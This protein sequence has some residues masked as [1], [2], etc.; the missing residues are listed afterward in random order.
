MSRFKTTSAARRR[1]LANRKRLRFAA[2]LAEVLRGFVPD[3]KNEVAVETQLANFKAEH[4][5]R[6]ASRHVKAKRLAAALAKPR[7]AK[8][9]RARLANRAR[10]RAARA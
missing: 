9:P 7:E 3:E 8:K 2:A 10:A 6:F 5:L 4:P 1:C